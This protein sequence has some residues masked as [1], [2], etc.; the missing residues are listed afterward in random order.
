MKEATIK[1]GEIKFTLANGS[2]SVLNHYIDCRDGVIYR[3]K[4][5]D[6]SG[7]GIRT[8]AFY[9]RNTKHESVA[10]VIHK[11]IDGKI[12]EDSLGFDTDSWKEFRKLFTDEAELYRT[13]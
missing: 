6:C 11:H 3:V 13:Y 9:C 7:Y 2:E 5:N 4:Y 1:R 10:L 8:E 12:Y